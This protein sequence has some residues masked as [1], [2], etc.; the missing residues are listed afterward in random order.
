[1]L[2]RK[3]FLNSSRRKEKT[4][5]FSAPAFSVMR[6]LPETGES[7]DQMPHLLPDYRTRWILSINPYTVFV[8]V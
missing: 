5:V 8:Y 3:R 2:N 1:M 7:G 4:P 6:N